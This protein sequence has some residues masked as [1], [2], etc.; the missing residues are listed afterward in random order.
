MMA[1]TGTG[2]SKTSLAD[3]T[4]QNVVRHRTAASAVRE[5]FLKWQCR[6][7]QNTVRK[8]AGKPSVSMRSSV[9]VD[10][11]TL[12]EIIFL[13]NKHERFSTVPEFRHMVLRTN[14][15]KKRYDSGLEFLAADYY[16]DKEEFTDQLTASFGPEEP[17]VGYLEKHR[18]CTLEFNQTRQYFSLPCEV[19][20]LDPSSYLYQATYWHNQLFN[21]F[22]PP[23]IQVV[24]FKPDWSLA[25]AEPGP[26]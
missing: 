25:I 19:N 2:D 11:V 13:I 9:V 6:A 24:A 22:M 1:S 15:P 3:D 26:S 4:H 21:P 10:N 7:R 23:G 16:Q 12:V 5:H 8:N 14:D 20:N 18:T 17:L